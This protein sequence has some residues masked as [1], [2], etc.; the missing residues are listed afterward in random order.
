MQHCENLKSYR[1]STL[2]RSYRLW[3]SDMPLEGHEQFF[4]RVK[5]LYPDITDVK[6]RDGVVLKII[7]TLKGSF[8]MQSQ[9]C[10]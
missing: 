8:R 7:T 5:I 3:W 1:D 4:P 10:C 2:S 6:N 9:N